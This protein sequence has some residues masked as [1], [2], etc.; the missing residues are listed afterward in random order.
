M[1]RGQGYAAGLV[2]ALSRQLLARGV[3]PMLYADCRNPS[4]NRLY[5][6]LGYQAVGEITELCFEEDL[7]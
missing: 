5:Q 6:K 2:R 1:Q 4:S 3:T 7:S